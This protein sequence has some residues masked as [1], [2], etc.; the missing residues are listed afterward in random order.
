MWEQ[1]FERQS[2]TAVRA[3]RNL[4]KFFVGV[5]LRSHIL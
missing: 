5:A 1:E 3:R 2:R 4:H